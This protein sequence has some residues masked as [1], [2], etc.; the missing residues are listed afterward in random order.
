MK[1]KHDFPVITGVN[2]D[3]LNRNIFYNKPLLMIFF[4]IIDFKLIAA[5]NYTK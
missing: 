5:K 3:Y 1:S 2:S 4:F